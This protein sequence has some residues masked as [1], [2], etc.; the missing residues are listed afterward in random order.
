MWQFFWGV[1]L[2]RIF[3]RG[4]YVCGNSPEKAI[5]LWW[6]CPRRNFSE[7]IIY[8]TIVRGT[9]TRGAI[10]RG[11]SWRKFSRE[12]LSRRLLARRQLAGTIVRGLIIRGQFSLG[13][14]VL[15]P[16]VILNFLQ[17]NKTSDTM[18]W[19]KWCHRI[20]SSTSRHATSYVCW[21]GEW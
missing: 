4:N 17:W 8:W 12:Q 3:P 14:I 2:G 6:K 11:L 13:E 1:F 9:I 20:W 5:F 21:T 19:M 16:Y 7:A 10:V 18:I 15:T